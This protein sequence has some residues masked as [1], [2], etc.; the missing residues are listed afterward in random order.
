MITSGSFGWTLVKAV[1]LS[2]SIQVWVWRPSREE[3]CTV[4]SGSEH[5][6][7]QGADMN[8]HVY[9]VYMTLSGTLSW[10]LTL[11]TDLPGDLVL[12]PG[13]GPHRSLETALQDS[14]HRLLEVQV[15]I[16][17]T[18]VLVSSQLPVIWRYLLIKWKVRRYFKK[19]EN[20][21]HIYHYIKHCSQGDWLVLYQMSRNMNKR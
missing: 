18:A 4:Y 19:D 17:S 14:L 10:S 21:C 3:E 5:D 8:H 1:D 15:R 16:N 11:I 13:A 6:Q 2:L 20:D 7:W 12:V 9:N